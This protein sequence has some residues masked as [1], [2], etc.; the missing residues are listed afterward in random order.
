MNMGSLFSTNEKSISL[1]YRPRDPDSKCLYWFN[2]FVQISEVATLC[3][4][5]WQYIPVTQTF[6]KENWI[7]DLDLLEAQKSK[8]MPLCCLNCA[9]E[10]NVSHPF[11]KKQ[12]KTQQQQKKEL[13]TY[14]ILL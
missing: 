1:G 4:Q 14:L 6:R 8:W 3:W 11:E 5:C 10:K 12:K 2:L 9:V 7:V 13:K